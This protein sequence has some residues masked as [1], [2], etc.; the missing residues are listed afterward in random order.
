MNRHTR[1]TGHWRSHKRHDRASKQSLVQGAVN[2]LHPYERE[3]TKDR[4]KYQ[5]QHNAER[6]YALLSSFASDVPRHALQCNRARDI[7]L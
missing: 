3:H 1:A 5:H 6:D 2:E 4:D 7:G